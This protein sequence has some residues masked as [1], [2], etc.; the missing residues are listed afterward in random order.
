LKIDFNEAA[1]LL[2]LMEKRGEVSSMGSDGN[3]TII[4]KI[5]PNDIDAIKKN[6]FS[7]S[8]NVSFK[9]LTVLL[10]L[11]LMAFAFYYFPI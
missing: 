10:I 3:R 5:A 1:R 8:N 4:Q 6:S 7:D 2:W 9:V 11:I